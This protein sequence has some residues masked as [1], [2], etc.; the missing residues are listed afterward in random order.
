MYTFKSSGTEI[1][2]HLFSMTRSK[3]FHIFQLV[4]TPF[5]T[6]VASFVMSVVLSLGLEFLLTGQ[7]SWVVFVISGTAASIIAT[8]TIDATIPMLPGLV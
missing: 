8:V 4:N 6:V 5:K 1:S 3:S 2:E 7:V